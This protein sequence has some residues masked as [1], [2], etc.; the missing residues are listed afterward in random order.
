MATL[1]FVPSGCSNSISP[2][3]NVMSLAFN[4]S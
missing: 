4:M 1:F 2:C 3:L